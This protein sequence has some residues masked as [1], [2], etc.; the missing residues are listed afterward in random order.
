[1]DTQQ[2]QA[3]DQIVRQG[4]FSKAARVLDI[5]QPTI[6]LRIQALEKEVG[7]ILFIRGGNRL[8]LTEMGASFLP[9]ARQALAALASGVE[10]AQLVTQGKRGQVSV[11]TLPTL[12]TG[13][14]AAV[15]EEL[16][17][18]HPQLD[19]IIHT[20]HNQ[21]IANM[22]YDGIVKLGLMT[23]PFF[24]SDLTLL[25]HV[26]E[27]LVPV[28]H[29]DHPLARPERVESAQM[30]REAAPFYFVD[31]SLD[32]RR[33]QN[34]FLADTDSGTDSDTVSRFEVPPQ[35]ARDL[36]LRGR[37]AALL[38]RSFIADDLRDGRLVELHVPDLPLLERETMLVCLGPEERLSPALQEFLKVFRANCSRAG[39]PVQ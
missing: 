20:G 9:Y 14:F 10:T 23:W 8:E 21:E 25:Q 6:S 33:W 19:L 24:R 31:W 12:A 37:G 26:K 16:H 29:A 18:R 11:G 35:T 34:Q 17:Q 5:A 2:L 36:L 4:S 32:V 27:P 28:V 3:F 13:F 22:L 38:T 15:L 1:M 39:K 30:K 7:G